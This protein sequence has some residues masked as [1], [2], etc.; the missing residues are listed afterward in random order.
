[1]FMFLILMGLFTAL[2]ILYTIIGS[3]K[4][5]NELFLY[6]PRFFVHKPTLD[7]FRNLIQIG[8]GYARAL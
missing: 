7:N 8:A 5:I 3:F 6:P 1:M 2:P 4:P